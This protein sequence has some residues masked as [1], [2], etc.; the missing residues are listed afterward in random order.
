MSQSQ[1]DEK[2]NEWV[3]IQ[4]PSPDPDS[5]ASSMTSEHAEDSE[6]DPKYIEINDNNDDD[7]DDEP[8][9]DI[10]SD[11]VDVDDDTHSCTDAT[12]DDET[13]DEIDDEEVRERTA[14][15]AQ[16]KKVEQQIQQIEA[17]I[18][19]DNMLYDGNLLPAEH[20]CQV[21]RDLNPEMFRNK[22]WSAKT[23]MSIN[24]AENTWIW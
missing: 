9:E 3:D 7:D 8:L 5:E 10:E 1:W 22:Q 15:P 17:T 11:L 2:L 16:V 23:I 14:S 19:Q 20:Y 13:D 4:D 21:I 12:D 24:N 18:V 6:Y